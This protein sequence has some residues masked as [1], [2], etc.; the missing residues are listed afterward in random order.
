[1]QKPIRRAVLRSGFVDGYQLVQLHLECGYFVGAAADLPKT[2]RCTECELAQ[3]GK[4]M[5]ACMQ[6]EKALSERH[7]ALM[8][9]GGFTKQARAARLS[10]EIL[11]SFFLG[12]NAGGTLSDADLSRL[13]ANLQRDDQRP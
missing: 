5:D 1:M 3:A 8:L 7:K 2:A 9:L 6:A 12:L 11:R 13:D 10:E 4:L